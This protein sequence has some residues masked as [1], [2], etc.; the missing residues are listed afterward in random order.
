MGE[1]TR[2]GFSAVSCGLQRPFRAFFFEKVALFWYY[3]GRA[4]RNDTDPDGL[5]LLRS[6]HHNGK[7]KI[8]AMRIRILFVLAVVALVVSASGAS[9]SQSDQ[10][11]NLPIR[12]LFDRALPAKGDK[13]IKLRG[14]LI[15]RK[16]ALSFLKAKMSDKDWKTAILAEAMLARITEPQRYLRYEQILRHA[17]DE[18]FSS[19]SLLPPFPVGELNKE[20]DNKNKRRLLPFFVEL[21]IKDSVAYLDYPSLGY[22][23]EFLEKYDRK[24][25]DRER[26]AILVLS[27]PNNRIEDI[28]KLP[29]EKHEELCRILEKRQRDKDGRAVFRG[30]ATTCLH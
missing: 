4:S 17:A 20:L 23:E 18:R 1:L 10:P 15:E 2:A 29:L 5:L 24:Y 9:A 21:A 19:M 30:Y 28:A 16:N 8:K 27:D 26:Y 13:Y 22:S 25:Y 7:R 3:G 6:R 11:Q 14:E 12:E